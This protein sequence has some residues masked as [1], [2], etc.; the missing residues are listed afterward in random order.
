MLMLKHYVYECIDLEER[1]D[2]EYTG[3][4]GLFISQKKWMAIKSDWGLFLTKLLTVSKALAKNTTDYG[5]FRDMSILELWTLATQVSV[6]FSGYVATRLDI[7]K[8]LCGENI[9]PY[10]FRMYKADLEDAN[11]LRKDLVDKLGELEDAY[12]DILGRPY[13]LGCEREM[14]KNL[15]QPLMTIEEA[16]YGGSLRRR[17]PEQ[18]QSEQRAWGENNV[19]S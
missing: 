2:R 11:K 9:K 12:N 17:T 5:P 8:N 14:R 10:P 19:T 16:H 7:V 15:G 1:W 13:A 4:N 18:I 3:F 6:S